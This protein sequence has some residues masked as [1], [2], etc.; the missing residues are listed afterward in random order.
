MFFFFGGGKESKWWCKN[1]WRAS[2]REQKREEEFDAFGNKNTS[3][4][5]N[6]ASFLEIHF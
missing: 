2:K 1:P 3:K 5:M 4:M 6:S